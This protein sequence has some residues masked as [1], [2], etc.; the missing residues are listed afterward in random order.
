MYN[1]FAGKQRSLVFPVMCNG[2][3]TIDY[4]ENIPDAG[5]SSDTTDDVTYG[6]WAHTGSFTI[7]P[8]VGSPA[9][10]DFTHVVLPFFNL[11]I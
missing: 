10:H 1:V 2:F 9:I 7:E 3:A 6:I 8:K 5:T 11:L 4:A